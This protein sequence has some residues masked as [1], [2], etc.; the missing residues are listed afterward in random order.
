MEVASAVRGRHC[1]DPVTK[2]WHIKYRPFR[3]HWIVLLMTVNKQIFA[4]PTERIIPEK[5]KAQFE[6]EQELDS[7]T[8]KTPKKRMSVSYM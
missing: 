1:Y 4:L 2:E 3:D 5:I 8:T 7:R 6:I